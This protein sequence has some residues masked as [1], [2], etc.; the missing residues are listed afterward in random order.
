MALTAFPVRMQSGETLH[1]PSTFA[2]RYSMTLELSDKEVTV[3]NGTHRQV[4]RDPDLVKEI[5]ADYEED[6]ALLRGIASR[7][8]AFTS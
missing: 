6:V 2:E 1:K 8:D 4:L 7:V 5:F 3:L